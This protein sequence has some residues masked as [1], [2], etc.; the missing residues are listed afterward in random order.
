[1]K[2][3]ILGTGTFYIGTDRSGPAYLLEADNKKI[4]IDCGPGTLM[5]LS[6]IGIKPEDLDYIFIS[7]FHAD[8]T[9]DLFALQMNLRLKEFEGKDYKTPIIFGPEG[10][11]DFTKKLSYIYELPAFDNYSKI[12]YRTYQKSIQLGK[13]MV[14]TFKVEHTAFGLKAKAYALRFELSNKVF[15]FSG[16]SVKCKGLKDASKQADLFICDSSY[17]KGNSN[18]AHLDTY[19]I[20]EIAKNSKVKKIVLTHIYPKSENIDLVSEVK[21]KYSG[22]VLQGKDLMKLEI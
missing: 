10:I 19:E 9:T 7:H 21:E 11:K 4:L 16:D 8:H 13:I 22:Q 2:I 1:M 6:E 5:R 17:S 15:V 14:K 3:T 12:E 18:L 20:G